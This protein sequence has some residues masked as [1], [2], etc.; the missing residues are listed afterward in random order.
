M[1]PVRLEP[2]APQSRVKH[3]TIEPLHSL[4]NSVYDLDLPILI[5]D[6][7]QPNGISHSYQIDQS[8]SF[9]RLVFHFYSNFNRTFCKQTVKTLIR[10]HVLWRLSWVCLVCLCLTEWTL[11]LNF[12][13][14]INQSRKQTNMYIFDKI[15]PPEAGWSGTFL[16]A[17]AFTF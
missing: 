1:T 17:H 14:I 15:A 6:P 7:F 12:G 2:A 5:I 10:S 11:Y 9:L 13:L 16:F 3:S 8:I 4:N